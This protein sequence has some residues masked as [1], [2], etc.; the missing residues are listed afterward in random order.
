MAKKKPAFKEGMR[1]IG[2]KEWKTYKGILHYNASY[3]MWM[4]IA[5]DKTFP[6]HNCGESISGTNGY[7]VSRWGDTDGLYLEPIEFNKLE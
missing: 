4:F 3:D 2:T 6:G 1:V 7:F 5:N